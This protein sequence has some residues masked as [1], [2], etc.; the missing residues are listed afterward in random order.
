MPAGL[1]VGKRQDEDTLEIELDYVIPSYR[2]FKMGSYLFE[3][4]KDFFLDRGY[5]RLVTYTD[6][7]VHARYLKKMGF[8]EDA[9]D[10]AR[11]L[12]CYVKTL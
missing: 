11:D 2:D 10:P 12:T 7:P 1:F 3:H 4:K 6:Q 8:R 5:R 9:C